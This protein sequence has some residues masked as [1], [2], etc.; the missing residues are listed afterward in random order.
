LKRLMRWPWEVVSPLMIHR[1]LT[2][3]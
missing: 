1:T 2:I 3:L